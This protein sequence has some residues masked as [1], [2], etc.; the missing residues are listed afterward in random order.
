MDALTGKNSQPNYLL[1]GH[2]GADYDV[3]S[4]FFTWLRGMGFNIIEALQNPNIQFGF[5]GAEE[6]IYPHPVTPGTI[7]EY[8]DCGPGKYNHHGKDEEGNSL[9]DKYASATRRVL[10]DFP[11]LQRDHAM[12]E[13]AD[14]A[15]WVDSP[16]SRP[17]I[18]PAVKEARNDGYQFLVD[19]GVE[20]DLRLVR[21]TPWP[22][23]VVKLFSN[24]SIESGDIPD[25][26]KVRAGLL[27]LNAW[28]NWRVVAKRKIKALLAD[29]GT[30]SHTINGL[31][32]LLIDNATRLTTKL[33][34][35][36]LRQKNF[37]SHKNGEPEKVI[38]VLIA[39]YLNEAGKE[40]VGITLLDNNTVEGMKD[41]YEEFCLLDPDAAE[42]G[43]IY[44]E[45]S[46]NDVE[47]DEGDLN[48]APSGDFVI[49]VSKT[50]I[51][52]MGQVHNLTPRCLTRREEKLEK[53]AITA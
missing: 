32:Y 52:T 19:K 33:V 2:T 24:M 41:L 26:E 47:A 23:D 27:M 12:R 35:Y 39:R 48:N 6:P 15:D 43:G 42:N 13:I 16:R 1:V 14:C 45:D 29:P 40:V 28:Y 30:M 3:L 22:I 8:F 18:N 25:E 37:W 5:M 34:R 4:G 36:H 46:G 38:D 31:N 51:I 20:R 17:A 7:V 53:E 9:K 49:Y 11:K 21:N 44:F 10:V 50:D